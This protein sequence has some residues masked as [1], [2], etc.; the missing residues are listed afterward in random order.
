VDGESLDMCISECD[1]LFSPSNVSD[2]Q[3]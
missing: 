3:E 1:D 2:V